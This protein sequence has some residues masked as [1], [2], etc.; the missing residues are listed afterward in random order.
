MSKRTTKYTLEEKAG[1]VREFVA[2][3]QSKQ[4]ISEYYKIGRPTLEAWIYRYERY[5]IEGLKEARTWQRYSEETKM[6]AVNDYLKQAGSLKDICRKYEI[7]S[8]QV[9]RQW[10]SKY[11]GGEPLKST[12]KGLSTMT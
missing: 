9:L 10:I 2:S 12:G 7:S 6:N 11:T 8:T 1:I 5:G 4:R 3:H